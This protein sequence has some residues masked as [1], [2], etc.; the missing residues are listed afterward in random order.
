MAALKELLPLAKSST[1]THYDHSNDP[2]F[3]QRHTTAE[4]E[5]S[6]YC[7]QWKVF[8]GTMEKNRKGV[9]GEIQKERTLAS[10]SWKEGNWKRPLKES[11]YFL[12]AIPRKEGRN[13]E[14]VCDPS[15]NT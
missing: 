4:A 1:A 11:S 13:S 15:E 12:I 14:V 2:W 10:L 9:E 8:K 5:R 3:K 6:R 7:L